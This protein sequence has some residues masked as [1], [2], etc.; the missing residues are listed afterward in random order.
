M[1]LASLSKLAND[2]RNSDLLQELHVRLTNMTQKIA[3]KVDGV[4]VELKNIKEFLAETRRSATLR[5]SDTV[6]QQMPLKPGVFQGRD[7]IIE[8][9]T[10]LLMKEETS[11]ICILGPGGMGK[12][13]VSLGIV[14]IVYMLISAFVP[15]GT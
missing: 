9:I 7:E 2:L 1:L 10:H 5:S 3:N 12:T 13:S 15:K 11:R 14:Y 6:Y 8:E 4:H